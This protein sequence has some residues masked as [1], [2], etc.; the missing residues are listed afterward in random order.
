VARS[1]LF[2]HTYHHLVL[3]YCLP[4]L[5]IFASESKGSLFIDSHWTL[6]KYLVSSLSYLN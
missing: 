1:Q 6:G 2:T 4:H 5:F 3:G